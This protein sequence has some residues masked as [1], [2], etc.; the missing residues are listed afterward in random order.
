MKR[1][2]SHADARPSLSQQLDGLPAFTA[3]SVAVETSEAAADS[4]RHTV[5]DAHAIILALLTAHDTL[6]DYEIRTRTGWKESYQRP[7]R[8]ELEGEGFLEK[9]DGKAGRPHIKRPTDTGCMAVA[10]RLT[11]LGRERVRTAA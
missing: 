3:P 6:T 8:W 10:Y 7:R 4:I 1:H 2:H 5:R 11:A 9:C